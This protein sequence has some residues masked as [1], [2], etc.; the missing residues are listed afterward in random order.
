MDCWHILQIAPTS[1]ER[2]IK[3]AYAK[4]LKTTRPDDDAEGYQRLR[5]A[6]DEALAIAPYLASEA[7]PEWSFLASERLPE[8]E[9]SEFRQ[10]KRSEFRQNEQSGFD[11][12]DSGHTLPPWQAGSPDEHHT[13]EAYRFSGSPKPD[14]T[15]N[16]RLPE[17]G[18]PPETDE[19]F[20][21]SPH[22]GAEENESAPE[23]FVYPFDPDIGDTF[24]GSLNPYGNDPCAALLDDIDA[25]FEGGGVP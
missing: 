9:Q 22:P 12:A 13:Y 4:L 17:N 20:S 1:D 15:E 21:G 3:R 2:A 10:N 6:F 14:T 11:Q 7:A 8:N 5:E 16:E 24:S 23:A 18:N 25:R 19:L